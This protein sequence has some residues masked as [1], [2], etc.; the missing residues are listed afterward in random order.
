VRDAH[1]L[2][3]LIYAHMMSSDTQ[4]AL[5]V[6]AVSVAAAAAAAQPSLQP[7]LVSP[8]AAAGRCRHIARSYA[9]LAEVSSRPGVGQPATGQRPEAPPFL[10][11][12]VHMSPEEF[13]QA[14]SSFCL[15]PC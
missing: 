15:G 13:V 11:A 2:C 3:N 1:I 5:S 8:C 10:D 14:C 6:E 9:G 4:L 12:R 7:L